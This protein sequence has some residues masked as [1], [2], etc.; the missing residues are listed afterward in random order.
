MTSKLDRVRLS[1]QNQVLERT[2]ILGT[3]S[4]STCGFGA[5]DVDCL[6]SEGL[7][8]S[9]GSVISAPDGTLWASHGEGDALEYRTYDERSMA[10]KLLHVDRDGRGLPGHPFCPGDADLT[11]DC[12]KI[13][14][15][16]FATPSVSS[17]GPTAR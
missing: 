1:A 5:D 6:P 9:V 13:H 2:T 17:C 3:E 16:G 8:H 7:T 10:G 11:H 4:Q 15:Q 12:T 14:S